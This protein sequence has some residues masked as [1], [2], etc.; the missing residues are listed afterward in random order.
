MGGEGGKVK[1]TTGMLLVIYRK[2]RESEIKH[3]GNEF[4]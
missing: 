2:Y 1:V 4:G 3:F